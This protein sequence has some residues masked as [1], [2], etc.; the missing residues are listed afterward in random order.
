MRIMSVGLGLAPLLLVVTSGSRDRHTLDRVI[1][2]RVT[3][4]WQHSLVVDDQPSV[5]FGGA[6]GPPITL[7][8]RI[9]GV[10]RL[11][12]GQIVVADG[13]SAELR[14]FDPTGRQGRVIG[15]PGSGPGEFRQLFALFL[16][17]ADTI[18]AYDVVQGFH[19]LDERGVYRR[20]ITYGRGTSTPLHLWPYGW[21]SGGYQLSGGV[22]PHDQASTGRLRD[23]MTFFRVD[24]AGSH[25]EKLFT[26]PAFDFGMVSGG[27]K[28]LV[29]FSPTIAVAVWPNRMC[30]GFGERYEIRCDDLSRRVTTTIRHDVVQKQVPTA[31]IERYKGLV[32][33][34]PIQG[35]AIIPPRV[36]ARREDFLRWT[37]FAKKQPV[38]AQFVAGPDGE[39]WV[40]RY[41]IDVDVPLVDPMLERSKTPS[42]WDVFAGNGR[43]VATVRVPARFRVFQAGK[44]YLLGVRVDDDDVEHV[45]MLSVSR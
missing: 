22:L 13:G 40:R 19:I 31:A 37:T 24:P 4:S 33:M 23:S 16:G 44:G 39:L 6:G 10:V 7:F 14:M 28:Q 30:V 34:E 15:R 42:T 26:F 21:L 25:P 38:F 9:V 20:T 8:N 32:R 18:I 45:S 2:N 5:E 11:S 12:T 3:A 41:D 27:P 29:V 43:W 1:G 35:S 36:R 17:P